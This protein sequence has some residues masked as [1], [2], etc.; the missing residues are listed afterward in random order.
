MYKIFLTIL[1]IFNSICA[2]DIQPTFILQSSGFVYDFVIDGSKL[3]AANDEGSV[4]IFDLNQ[5]ILLD[6][7]FIKPTFSSK[8]E[9]V[10][11][12]VISVDRYN[13]KTLIVS[14][15]A[16]GYRNIW[17]H[18]GK[19]SKNII[20][21][22]D[23]MTIKEA[24][25]IDDRNFIFGTLGYDMIHYSIDDNAIAY[26]NHIEQSSF[27]DMELSEDKRIMITASE[28][29][30]V[31]LSDV[32][33]GK[34]LKKLDGLNVDNIYKIA[35]RKGTIITAGQDRRVGIYPKDAKPYY[36]KSNFLVYSASLSPSGKIGVYSSGEESYLQ[37]FDIKTGNKMDRLIGHEAIPSTTKFFDEFGVFSA[38]YE[39]KIFYWHLE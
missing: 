19:K 14:T 21:L 18:D 11:S 15:T 16:N 5:Q 1:I 33:S 24:R 29:G 10:T 35:Y 37:L 17:L 22:R 20:K 38:G 28:S 25:F 2:K 31:T 39:N 34:I 12:K 26:K 7:I 9:W 27:S 32:K 13:K 8:G 6:E 36:I 23:K 4:E 3:Y 30:Q